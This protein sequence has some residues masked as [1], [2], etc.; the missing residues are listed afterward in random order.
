[1]TRRKILGLLG[2]LIP[3][4]LLA[5]RGT[6]QKGQAVVCS[7]ESLKCPLG[8]ETCSNINAPL[9]VGNGNKEYPDVGQLF[10]QKVH[11]CDQCGVLF[12][13]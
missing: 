7:G 12:C 9:V 11:K 3:T 5:Q 13:P 2:A 4:S 1:M 6:M 8:H 10:E